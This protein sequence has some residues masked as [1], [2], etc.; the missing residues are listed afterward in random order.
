MVLK[1]LNNFKKHKNFAK[2]EL[3][4][5]YFLKLVSIFTLFFLVLPIT[6]EP[7][8][9][10][11]TIIS[12][13][14]RIQ[15]SKG[16]FEYAQL[17]DLK[18]NSVGQPAMVI[19]FQARTGISLR[20][21]KPVKL[22][23]FTTKLSIQV[24][25][26]YCNERIWALFNDRLGKSYRLPTTILGSIQI[27]NIN[28]LQLDLRGKLRQRPNYAIEESYIEFTGWFIEPDLSMSNLWHSCHLIMQAPKFDR[29]PYKQLLPFTEVE[30][31]L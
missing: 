29:Q 30:S 13:Q 21:I 7:I 15:P 9:E 16:P 31:K 23:G 5:F 8:T 19:N 14:Y 6:A 11:A 10:P 1:F 18:E 17:Y 27:G 25:G 3:I 22:T 28:T 12:N 24:E 2:L 4:E 26:F 20:L